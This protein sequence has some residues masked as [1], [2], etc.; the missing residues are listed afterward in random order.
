MLVTVCPTNLSLSRVT[1]SETS[2]NSGIGVSLKEF[3]SLSGPWIG[4]SVQDG[5][6]ISERIV[7]LIF[8]GSISGKGKD[9]DGNFELVGVYEPEGQRVNL[10]RVYTWTSE[11]SQDGVGIPYQYEG[12]WDG[13]MAFGLWHP[14]FEPSYGGIFEMW[15]EQEEERMIHTHELRHLEPLALG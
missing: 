1:Y 14:L 5:L 3:N 9:K 2:G 11:P 4:F 6:R 7:L 15:P 10:T 8:N 13:D 12:V